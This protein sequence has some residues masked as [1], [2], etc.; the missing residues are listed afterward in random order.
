MEKEKKT[1]LG[2]KLA[3]ISFILSIVP[4]LLII[5]YGFIRNFLISNLILMAWYGYL[6]AYLPYISLI[7]SVISIIFVRRKKINGMGFAISGAII[8]LIEVC[9]FLTIT[10][11]SMG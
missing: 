2:S 10:T 8:S 9:L 7:F 4:I 6:V 11:N 3:I 1:N 5:F